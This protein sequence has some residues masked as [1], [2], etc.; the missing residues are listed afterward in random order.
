[1]LIGGTAMLPGFRTRLHQELLRVM[2]TPTDQEK[3]HYSSVLRL[4]QFLKLA[5]ENGGDVFK[6][7]VRAW[8]GGMFSEV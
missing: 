8:I 2:R 6:A 4:H 3:S 7:N 1:M 5:D